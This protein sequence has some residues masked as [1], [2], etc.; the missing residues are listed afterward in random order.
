MNAE[1]EQ[2]DKAMNG[3]ATSVPSTMPA[4]IGHKRPTSARTPDPANSCHTL[5]T[6]DGNSM[7]E[8]NALP[9]AEKALVRHLAGI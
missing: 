4:S 3:A 1:A 9:R 7:R 8:L 6:N 2:S 5:V